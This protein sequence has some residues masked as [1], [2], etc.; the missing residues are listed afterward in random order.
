MSLPCTSPSS[1]GGPVASRI[2]LIGQSAWRQRAP[3]LA[4]HSHGQRAR[5]SFAGFNPRLD[6]TRKRLGAGSTFAAVCRCFPGKGPRRRRSR[7]RQTRNSGMFSLAAGASFEILRPQLV[8]PV[9]RLAIA[10]FL[11]FDSLFGRCWQT[12]G[13]SNSTGRASG[14]YFR[15]RIP[16]ELR[17]WHRT[18]PGRT[19]LERSLRLIAQ[20]PAIPRV[21]PARTPSQGPNIWTAT[22]RPLSGKTCVP[23]SLL[24]FPQD[25]RESGP[26]KG[27][28]FATQEPAKIGT[29]PQPSP[30]NDQ[31]VFATPRS[32]MLPTQLSSVFFT[33][34][35]CDA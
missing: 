16:P 15:S 6:G 2:L 8:L 28:F 11:E 26:M 33:L 7:P 18:E 35:V 31:L 24:E 14:F 3:F 5:R 21:S 23:R 25:A 19:L 13:N 9:G 27:T 22:L 32:A 34:S 12:L 10:Q 17:P 30:L 20:H 4:V 29:I 1:P